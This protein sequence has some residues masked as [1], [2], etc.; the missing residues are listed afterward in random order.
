MLLSSHSLRNDCLLFRHIFEEEF[1]ESEEMSQILESMSIYWGEDLP[2]SLTYVCKT[3]DSLGKGARWSLPPLFLSETRKGEDTEDDRLFARNLL[4]AAYVNYQKYWDMVAESVSNWDNDRIVSTDM[5]LI[6]QGM[7]EAVAFPT[8]PV[9]VT[10]NEYVEISKYFG[11]PKSKLFVNGILDR[12]IQ[13]LAAD[14]KIQKTG[15]GLM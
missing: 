12:V 15:K 11:T 6:I 8:I 4:R 9:K 7:A 13:R 10:I 14:G 1:T 2:Y 5:C 3:L